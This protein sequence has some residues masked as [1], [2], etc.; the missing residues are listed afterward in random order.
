MADRRPLAA[1]LALVASLSTCARSRTV[2]LSYGPPS[3]YSGLDCVEDAIGRRPL[4]TRAISNGAA[5]FVVDFFD[6]PANINATGEVL[7]RAC[8]GGRCVPLPSRRSVIEVSA[9]DLELGPNPTT[10]DVARAVSR[11]LAGSA[12]T[13]NAPDDTVI[14]RVVATTQRAAELLALDSRG[15]YPDFAAAQLVGCSI[16]PPVTFDSTESPVYLS[17]PSFSDPCTL[18]DVARC[19]GTR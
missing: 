12:I 14:L 10:L 13:N 15:R 1:A 3:S 7:L 2:A 8:G 19:A 5:T 11:S 17:I 9:A 4:V 18:T 16:T 6:V